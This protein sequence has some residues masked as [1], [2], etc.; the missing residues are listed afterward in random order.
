M[1]DIIVHTIDSRD[2]VML[3]AMQNTSGL[4]NNQI[5]REIVTAVNRISQMLLSRGIN[6]ADLKSVLTPQSDRQEI[7]L[8]F[9]TTR[10]DEGWYGLPIQERLLPL[11][12][13]AGSHSFLLGDLLGQD[14]Q[15]SW[16]YNQFVE[17]LQ[18]INTPIRYLHSNQFFCV[19]IN[20]C[21]AQTI[22]NINQGFSS[23]LPYIGYSDVTYASQFKTYLSTCLTSR[24]IKFRNKI[25]QPHED[26]LPGDTNQNTL[27]YPFEEAKLTCHSV[28]SM[29][30][31]LLLSF[32]IERPVME[33][34]EIDQIYSLNAVSSNPTD[35]SNCIIEID[36][37]KLEYLKR[38]KT[39]TLKLLG[40]LGQPKAT[41][42]NL[43]RAKLRSNY[44]YNLR[45]RSDY[46]VTMFNMLLELQAIDTGLP[47][48]VVV[49][50]AYEQERN[51]IRLITLY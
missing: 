18:S 31:D 32:K 14:E 26:D 37:N 6:Y 15:Q 23:Y 40:V 27:G 25:I 33:G 48:R 34:F 41:L 43:I 21:S 49:S 22:R 5:M 30:F 17:H 38:E 12:N 11:L 39:G 10:I 4:D 19:Y 16:I 42:E 35:V 2:N 50:F 28:P 36:E 24:Y 45:F 29:Y 8:F 7:V 1:S 47:V 3:E 46:S 13:P 44:L 20:N 51:A 9:D